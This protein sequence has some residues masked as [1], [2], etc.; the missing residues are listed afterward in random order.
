MIH[1]VTEGPAVIAPV[2]RGE[3]PP[4]YHFAGLLVMYATGLLVAL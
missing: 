4:L 2:A 3:R 1:N